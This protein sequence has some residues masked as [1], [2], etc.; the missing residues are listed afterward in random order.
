[1]KALFCFW[2]ETDFVLLNLSKDLHRL[3]WHP[4]L[5]T[6]IVINI[7]LCTNQTLKFQTHKE[8]GQATKYTLFYLPLASALRRRTQLQSQLSNHRKQI[9]WIPNQTWTRDLV[10]STLRSRRTKEEVILT[11]MPAPCIE[12]PSFVLFWCSTR[13]VYGL[14]TT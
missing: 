8:Y 7:Q 14:G 9:P 12:E 5:G 11:R 3:Q 13:R 10:S 4:S 6:D 2:L 1:M